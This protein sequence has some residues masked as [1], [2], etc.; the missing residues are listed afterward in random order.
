MRYLFY[1]FSS[2]KILRLLFVWV[3]LRKPH[4][5]IHYL[6]KM[7]SKALALCNIQKSIQLLSFNFP[8]SLVLFL[9]SQV[10]RGSYTFQ[11]SRISGQKQ[12][13]SCCQGNGEVG[14]RFFALHR[15][16]GPRSGLQWE[17]KS[18]LS[19]KA[20]AEAIGSFFDGSLR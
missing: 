7:H 9:A 10:P 13:G 16:P 8:T 4:L 1:F 19:R 20:M 14:G 12:G 17:P 11:I 6:S 5:T 18:K 15:W 3:C 2:R